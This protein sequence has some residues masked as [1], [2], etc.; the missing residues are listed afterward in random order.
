MGPST[1]SEMGDAPITWAELKAWSEVSN[2]F[3]DSWEVN[4]LKR[5]AN[6]YVYQLNISSDP[7]M[8]PPWQ[9]EAVIEIPEETNARIDSKL[10][11]LP[12]SLFA[13]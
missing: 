8:G 5:L 11:S 1:S 2:T 12:R 3:L 6:E 7:A 4:I 13:K 10:K 9:A